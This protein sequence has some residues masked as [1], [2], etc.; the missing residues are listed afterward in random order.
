M[1]MS[2]DQKK[3]D[4]AVALL[5]RGERVTL[6]APVVASELCQ[7]IVSKFGQANPLNDADLTTECK[8]VV[9]GYA[10]HVGRALNAEEQKIAYSLAGFLALKPGGEARAYVMVLVAEKIWFPDRVSGP[11]ADKLTAERRDTVLATA[12]VHAK[13]SLRRTEL[14]RQEAKI[15]AD[16]QAMSPEQRAAFVNKVF[17]KHGFAKAG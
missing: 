4:A 17:A 14:A 9:A 13:E 2:E 16:R 11:K 12:H 5:L 1:S 6:T 3:F 8:K 7:D 10:L 15:S